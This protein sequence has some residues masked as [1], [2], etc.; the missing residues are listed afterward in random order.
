MTRI[1]ASISDVGPGAADTW[2]TGQLSLTNTTDMSAEVAGAN[3]TC[4]CILIGDLV[5]RIPPNETV[6]IPFRMIR[7]STT[8][9]FRKELTLYLDHPDQYS[10]RSNIVGRVLEEL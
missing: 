9:D 1:V 5:P 10:V 4:G 7:P 8:G 6:S 3:A 2:V